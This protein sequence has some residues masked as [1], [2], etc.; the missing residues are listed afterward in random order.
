MPSEE[1]MGVRWGKV[2]RSWGGEWGL[3]SKMKKKRIKK[4]PNWNKGN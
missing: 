4:H 3:V 2:R 1:W